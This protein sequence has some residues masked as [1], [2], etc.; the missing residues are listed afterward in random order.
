[1]KNRSKKKSMNHWILYFV[2][3]FP[4]GNAKCD[5]VSPDKINESQNSCYYD[6][7][8]YLVVT[9]GKI[10]LNHFWFSKIYN[11]NK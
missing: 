9:K 8:N 10:K 4:R 5:K 3:N 1:M 7:Y 11:N 6:Y 2:E